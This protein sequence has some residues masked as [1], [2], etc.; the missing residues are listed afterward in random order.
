VLGGV[1]VSDAGEE[2]DNQAIHGENLTQPN[3]NS[4]FQIELWIITMAFLTE[5]CFVESTSKRAA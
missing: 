2:N 1:K 4:N 5:D 3:E